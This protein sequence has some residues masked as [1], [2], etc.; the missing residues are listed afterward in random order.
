MSRLTRAPAGIIETGT[1]IGLFVKI[2][3][4]LQ[5]L[6]ISTGIEAAEQLGEIA[7]IATPMLGNALLTWWLNRRG[8]PLAQ[9][10]GMGP[11]KGA[12]LSLVFLALLLSPG[13]GLGLLGIGDQW[14][15]EDCAKLDL[16]TFAENFV[17]PG[18]ATVCEDTMLAA[19]HTGRAL[20]FGLSD[21]D[22][23]PAAT[24][25]PMVGVTMVAVE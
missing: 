24:D 13:C 1:V 5:T 7:L 14:T 18:D 8:A 16:V 12:Q 10:L 19:Y 2:G 20:C 21:E 23:E 3:L 15:Q 9:S 4:Y 22:P 6:I 11:M 17:C 25:V